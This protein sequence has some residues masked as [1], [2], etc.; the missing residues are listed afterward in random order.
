MELNHGLI[1]ADD[2]VQEHPEV[3]TARMSRAKW[4]D[5]IP[6]IAPL[7][8]GSQEWM[9]EGWRVP[10]RGVA[11]ANAAMTDR[12]QEPKRWADVPR[13]VFSPAERLKAMDADGVDYSILYPTV[14]GFAGQNFGN[15]VDPDLELACVQ[16][17][18]DWLIEEWAEASPRFVPQCIVPIWPMDRTVAE[19][20]RAVKKGHKGIIYPA[21][22]MELRHVPHIND[23]AYDPL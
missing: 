1:S 14:S 15:I 23:A 18:N 4:G 11:V 17:Y 3:W 10:L 2:H 22:P 7:D 16:T 8:D 6:H 19:I 13:A 9:I 5:R 20:K 21:S 12:A